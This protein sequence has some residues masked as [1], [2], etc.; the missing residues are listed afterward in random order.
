MYAIRSYYDQATHDQLTGLYNRQKFNDIL[1]K[2]I[3]REKRYQN[4][5]SMIIFDIDNFKYFNDTYG[6]D[7]YN[8]V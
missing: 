6:H 1:A 5:L 4:S 2:E 3:K 8:F 7:S